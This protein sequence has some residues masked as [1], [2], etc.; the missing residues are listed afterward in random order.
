M[1]QYGAMRHG[2][3]NWRRALAVACV[4][5]SAALLSGC[6]STSGW[7]GDAVGDAGSVGN[8]F[9]QLFGSSSQPAGTPVQEQ[10]KASEPTCPGVDI[11]SGASTLAVGLP[12]KPA[13]GTDLRYQGTITDTARE[14]TLSGGT[15][16]AKIGV[17]GRIIVGPA[18]APASVTVPIRIAVVQEGPQPKTVFSKVYQTTVAVPSDQPSAVYSL[19]A[20]DISYPVPGAEAA[21]SYIFYVGFDPDGS[22]PARAKPPKRSRN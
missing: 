6:G 4:A 8:R 13:S 11:R 14:C 21:E 20:E 1:G 16:A 7:L 22:R 12:G 17:Q 10:R 5:G 18:G 9:S 19:V 15:V 3:L 2:E